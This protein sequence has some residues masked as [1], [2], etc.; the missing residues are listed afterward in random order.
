MT[1][2]IK[3]FVSFGFF[4]TQ[5][6]AD[7]SANKISKENKIYITSIKVSKTEFCWGLTNKFDPRVQRTQ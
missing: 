6:Q 2:K 7:K 3:E 5:E 4:K 1:K